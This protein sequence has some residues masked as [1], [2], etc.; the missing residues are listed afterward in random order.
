MIE[1]LSSVILLGLE[2]IN[3]ITKM[4]KKKVLTVREAARLLGTPMVTVLRWAHQ[5]KVPCKSKKDGYFFKELELIEWAGA[6]D[7][8]LASLGEQKKT[9]LPQQEHG[10]GLSR[11]L[12]R[13][14]VIQGVPG[15]DIY[16]V[17]ENVLEQAKL[18]DGADKSL[19]FDELINREEIAST[20]IGK[21]V[22]IPHPRSPLNLALEEPVITA[23]YLEQP[24]DF[25]A[26]DGVDVFVLF[27]MLSP[28]TPRH[29][30]LLSKLSICLRDQR[31]RS[32]LEQRAGEAELISAI[33]EIETRLS[34]ATTPGP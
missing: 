30:E 31:F 14:G 27:L 15:S 9:T 29:L 4:K 25:N 10:A 3:K 12:R 33:E 1:S 21:G 20:G 6:H 32:L 18:P 22:A 19:V 5:G 28:S 13:G 8:P 11:A 7:M 24:V 26:V 2:I 34:P 23:A 17:M 16:S